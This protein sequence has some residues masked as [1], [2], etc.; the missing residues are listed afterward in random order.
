MPDMLVKLYDLPENRALLEE[1]ERKG[2]RIIRA[3]APNKIK[4]SEFV[5]NNFGDRWASECDVAFSR[6]PISCV[7]AV[8]EEKE[9]LGFACYETTCKAFFGPTGVLE[10]YRGLKIGKALLISALKGLKEMGY[11][12]AI[13]GGPEEAIG[14]YEKSVKAT[15]IQG[16]NPGIY[17][18]MI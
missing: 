8:D 10:Q 4:V 7:I 3:M 1:L 13:I 17:K 14:F 6:N 18:D 5:R 11:A 2:I 12:Y 16:S 9:I 15:V